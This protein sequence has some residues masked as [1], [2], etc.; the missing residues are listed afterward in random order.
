MSRI[1]T[2]WF[3]ISCTSRRYSH[4]LK[5]PWSMTLNHTCPLQV[6]IFSMFGKWVTVSDHR[7]PVAIK[8]SVRTLANRAPL[9]HADPNHE[10]IWFVC[11]Q[12]FR[13][14][15]PCVQRTTDELRARVHACQINCVWPDK[16]RLQRA[17][18]LRW[19]YLSHSF[20]ILI[21]A[22]V[23][24]RIELVPWIDEACN[25]EEEVEGPSSME[26]ISC[27]RGLCLACRSGN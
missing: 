6:C 12:S 15:M 9:L 25:V 21:A 27:K 4:M 2:H 16:R 19:S 18:I 11:M 3:Y 8:L 20:W 26:K 7:A 14:C 23:A 1:T 24:R 13:S 17:S 10:R 5:S 22:K